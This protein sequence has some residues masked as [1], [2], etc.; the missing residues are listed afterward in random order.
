MTDRARRSQT[1][2][3][4]LTRG[5]TAVAL[6]CATIAGCA[7]GSGVDEP[8]AGPPR[9][10]RTADGDTLRDG[11]DGGARDAGS[12]GDGSPP[13][14]GARDGAAPLDAGPPDA[15]LPIDA[16]SDSGSDGGCPPT[17][18]RIAIVELM[19]S[20]RSGAGDRGEWLELYNA[21]DCAVDLTGLT[22][23]SPDGLAPPAVAMF[24][25]PSGVIAP[26]GRFVL[27]QSGVP[28]EN[29]DLPFDLTY[30][31][32]GVVLDNGGDSVSLVS[33]GTT[34]DRVAWIAT[35][36][37]HGASRSFPDDRPIASNDSQVRFCN[38]TAVYSEAAGGP[39]R[40]TPRMPN[41]TCP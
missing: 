22:L 5:V 21:G 39:Y 18:E 7:T 6:W 32:S 29:H 16:G 36:Y 8:D 10:A 40:G 1:V 3:R 9:D 34:I 35:D 25:I 17:S 26:G 14:S 13:D 24:V 37:M 19:I 4:T 41:G 28:G 15:P 20:S 23:V 33:A 27:A 30:A 31:G 12:R 2:D 38:A 11:G